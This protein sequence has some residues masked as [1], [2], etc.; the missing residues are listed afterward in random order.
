MINDKCKK[1]KRIGEKLFLK[2]EKCYTP[3]CA[4]TAGAGVKKRGQFRGRRKTVSEYGIQLKEKQKV[5]FLYGLREK[6][7]RN[8]IIAAQK[9]SGS[10]TSKKLLEFLES[11]LDNVVFRLGFA[12]SRN[13]ARQIVSHGHIIVNGIKTDIPSFAVKLNDKISIRPQ[14]APSGAFSNLDDKLKKYNPPAWLNLDKSKK[15]GEAITNPSGE[16]DIEAVLD[17]IIGFYSR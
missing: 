6:Q 16:A 14:S 10:D 11:R 17:S 3:K 4:L 13:K 12:E 8:Y 7:F 1:C 15:E 2:G 5:K 9:K